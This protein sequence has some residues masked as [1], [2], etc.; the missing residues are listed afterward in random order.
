MTTLSA[1]PQTD[2]DHPAPRRATGEP[3]SAG[4]VLLAYLGEH[5]D[6][7][8]VEAERA[9]TDEPDAVH[10]VRVNSRRLRSALQAYR[11]LLDRERTEPVVDLLREFGRRMAPARDTEVLEERI[12]DQLAELPEDLR[13]GPVQAFT[14]RYFSR[15][16][17]Q[18]RADVVAELDGEHYV[19]LRLA[20][21]DLLADPPLTKRAGRPAKTELPAVVGRTA[22]RLARAVRA[23]NDPAHPHRDEAIHA[24]RKAAK[25]L[26]YATDVAVPAVGSQAKRFAKGLKAFQTALGEHQDTVVARAMLREL[27]AR[28]DNGFAFGVLYGGDAARAERIEEELPGLWKAAWRRRNRKWLR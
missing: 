15:L 27:G 12:T 26:R 25:R 16:G 17:A 3:G 22:R 9:R 6:R 20:L 24:A 5:T 7:L 1:V 10:Q 8:A 18:A 14:T 11:P 19:R 13:L 28:A 2:S 4:A 23:A 21:D